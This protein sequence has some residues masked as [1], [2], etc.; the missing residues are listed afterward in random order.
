[1]K[2]PPVRATFYQDDEEV[3]TVTIAAK[4]AAIPTEVDESSLAVSSNAEIPD[5]VLEPELEMVIEIDPDSTVDADLLVEKRIPEEGRARMD[6]NDMPLFDLTVVPLLWEE[7]PDSSV[8]ELTEDMNEE[9]T[10]FTDTH[11]LLPVGEMDVTVHGDC[12]ELDERHLHSAQWRWTAL[13]ADGGRDGPLDGHHAKCRGSCRSGPCREAAGRTWSI[14]EAR[15]DRARIRAQYE[16]L[17]RP[18]R[19][20]RNS[21]DP[22]LPISAP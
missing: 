15:N 3:H 19:W 12:L 13:R 7:D 21:C 5:S 17:P 14:P 4:S 11:M 6:V 18:L 20:G 8:L 10:L 2:I 16:P 9:D 1:M 22:G